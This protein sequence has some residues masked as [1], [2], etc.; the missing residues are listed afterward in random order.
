VVDSACLWL[1]VL[2]RVC[3]CLS[4]L[5]SVCQVW[6]TTGAGQPVAC[7]SGCFECMECRAPACV[8]TMADETRA[9][10]STEEA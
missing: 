6:H 1:T 10:K 2:T 7:V 3:L 5:D 9:E 4:V 8:H